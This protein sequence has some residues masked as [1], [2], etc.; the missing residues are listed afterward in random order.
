[1]IVNIIDCMPVRRARRHAWRIKRRWRL[2][3]RVAQAAIGHAHPP[4]KLYFGT[5][6]VAPPAMLMIP[7]RHGTV[8]T[9]IYQPAVGDSAA[10]DIRARPPVYVHFHGGAFV[11][12]NPRQD[13]HI[14]S[15]LASEVG[16]VVVAVDYDVAPQVTYPVAEEESYDVT[17]WVHDHSD[18]LGWDGSRLAVGGTS[19]GGKLAI[20]VAQL[21]HAN[22][23]P[24]LTAVVAAYAV[25]DI[26]RSDRTSSKKRPRVNRIIQRLPLNTYW[27]DETRRHEPIA[28]PLYDP[29]LPA[30]MPPILIMTGEHDTLAPEMDQLAE[31]I[32]RAG[33]SVRHRRFAGTDHSFTNVEPVET[34][35]EAITLIGQF[36]VQAYRGN[37]AGPWS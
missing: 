4:R 16:A 35:Y 24:P 13:D 1:M 11:G 10:A 9:F 25:A 26:S 23:G 14:C 29:D 2:A 33:G 3:A 30:A 18:E 22:A 31:R 8:A 15:Y 19:A 17:G 12:R 37:A 5:R 36:L 21:A 7:T 32:S 27:V 34:A 28:S 6:D 20:N